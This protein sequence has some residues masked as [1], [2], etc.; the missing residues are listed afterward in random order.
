M[1]PPV[2]VPAGVAFWFHVDAYAR[3]APPQHTTTGGV[4]GPTTNWYRR[5]SNGMVWTNSVSVARQMFRIHCLP[6]T[7]TVPVL[8]VDQPPVQGQSITFTVSGGLPTTVGIF[9]F[10]LDGTLWAGLPTPVDLGFIGASGCSMWTSAELILSLALDAAGTGATTFAVPSSPSLTG[11]AIF[12]QGGVLAPGTNA[13]GL[14]F[15]NAGTG[16]IGS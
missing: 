7:P 6:A 8:S 16:I 3:V 5:P 2:T 1:N 13:L 4:N 12:N 14:I 9:M 15:S 11:A 10:G